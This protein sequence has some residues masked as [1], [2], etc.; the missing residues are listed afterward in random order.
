LRYPP[1]LAVLGGRHSCDFGHEPNRPERRVLVPR[2]R[3][4][5]R[6]SSRLEKARL[7]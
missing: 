6:R 5:D 3:S 7:L 2:H 1:A 4:D